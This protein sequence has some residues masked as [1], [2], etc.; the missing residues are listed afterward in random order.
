MVPFG[1]IHSPELYIFTLDLQFSPS[2]HSGTKVLS[3]F[4]YNVVI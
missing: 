3:T 2:P 1:P 4:S